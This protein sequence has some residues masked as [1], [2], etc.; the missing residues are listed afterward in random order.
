MNEPRIQ[1][2]DLIAGVRRLAELYRMRCT[3][4]RFAGTTREESR[5]DLLSK[6]ASW[7]K[8]CGK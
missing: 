2:S 8:P 6:A 5:M 1:A 4:A 3:A 7:A